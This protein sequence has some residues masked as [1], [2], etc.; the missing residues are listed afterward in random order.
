MDQPSIGL[1]TEE[2]GPDES[3]TARTTRR[4]PLWGKI[5]IG[6]GAVLLVVAIAGFVIHVPYS[7][8]APGEAVKLTD[9]VRVDGAHTFPDGRGDIR[10]LFVRERNHV[11]LWRYLQARFDDDIELFK[12]KEL[13][14]TGE[15]QPDLEVEASAQMNAGE[16]RRDEGRAASGRV[17][18]RG[19]GRWTRRAGSAAVTSC[20][21][22]AEGE[23]HHSDCRR[24]TGAQQSRPARRDRQAS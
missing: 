4:V 1:S 16:D 11:N 5:G 9:L 19:V 12:E 23:R 14:P 6:F 2:V 17:S 8:I 3:I 10:L 22:A 7:T 13:N 15:S 24:R 20:R 18:R 21:Q